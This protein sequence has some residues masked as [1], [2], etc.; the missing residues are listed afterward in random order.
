MTDKPAS[1]AR[2][3]G[4]RWWPAAGWLAAL[5]FLSCVDDPAGPAPP[6]ALPTSVDPD[7]AALVALYESTDGPNWVNSQ[8]WL[9]DAPLGEW[10]GVDTDRNG[11]VRRLDL[12]G[13]GDG[14]GKP[15]VS[16]GLSGPVPSEIGSLT[17]LWY[18]RLYANNLTG[19]IPAELGGLVDL[20][21]L[22][23][24]IN[25]LSGPLPPELGRL[26]NLTYLR[27]S[28]NNLT[29]PIPPELGALVNLRTLALARN[30]LSR[31]IPAE[32][33]G[34]A[35]L[36][37]LGLGRNQLSGPI[38]PALGGLASLT[39]LLLHSNDLTGPI[40][41][42]LGG[43][44]NL[45]SLYL[46]G[47]ELTGPIPRGF[48]QLDHLD[49]LYLGRSRV[50]VP[51]TSAFA[52]WL[53]GIENHDADAAS[54]CN[55]T[56][57]A[58][59]ESLY[60]A[61]GGAGW[62]QS[63]GWT[64]EDAVAS[65]YG[66]TADSLGRVTELDLA[67]NALNGRLPAQLGE[68]S[69]MTIL[70]IGG[71]VLAGRLPRTL[72]RLSLRELDYADTQLCAP[73]EAA[74]QAW[75][76]GIPS[77]EGTGIQCEPLSDRKI[78]EILYEATGGPT[79]G[80]S[81]DWLTNAPLEDWYGVEVD[82]EGRAARLALQSSNLRGPIPPELGGL[83]NLV[84]LDLAENEL[85]GP[86]PPALGELSNLTT[87]DLGRNA[88]TGA[89][90]PALGGL[91]SLELL[92]LGENELEGPIPAALGNISGLKRLELWGNSLTGTIPPALG[93]LS[94]L[95]WL[96]LHGNDLSGPIPPELGN[97]SSL[98]ELLL[99]DNGFTGPIPRELGGLASVER[100]LLWGNA[101]TGT[102]PPGLGYVAT[103]R[104][105]SVRD[106]ALSG[107]IPAELGSLSSLTYLDLRRNELT[108]LLP[109]QLGDLSMLE[110]LVVDDN[111]LMGPVPREFGGMASLQEMSLSNNRS[112]AGPFPIE[113]A[114]LHRL[115]VLLA[116]GTRLCA[117]SDPGFQVWLAGIYK[118]RI[119][120]CVEGDLPAAY[121][122]QA[123][124]SRDFPVPL[125]A[126][127]KALLR[128]FPTASRT[129][130]QGIPA[131]RARFYRDG[132]E[133]H[134][135]DIP[136][137]SEPIP[138]TVDESDLSKSANAGIPGHVVQP[139]LEIVIEVDPDGTLDPSLGVATR[140]PDTGRLPVEVRAV[141]LFDL[142]LIPFIWSETQ[143]SSIVDLVR[144]MTA[145]PENHEM[146]G[147]ARALLPIGDLAVTAHEPVLTSTNSARALLNQTAVIRALEGGT[148]H[149]KGMMVRPLLGPVRGVAKLPGRSTFS[150]PAPDVIA[151]ELGHNL[152]L[153]H[154][155]CGL[156]GGPDPS[157]PYA[158]GSIGAWGYDSR[159]GGRLVQPPTPDLMSY[160]GPPDW[161]SDYHFTNALRFRLSDADSVG[162]P[163]RA[164]R[165][166][167]MLLWGGV[168]ADGVPFLEPAV[169]V[170]APPDLPRSDGA[171]RLSGH[172]AAGDELFS[173]GFDMPEVA[174]GDGSSG[175]AFVLP[176]RPGW[177]RDLASITLSG[178]GGS[179]T[180]DGETDRPAAI[181]RDPRTGT[182]RGILHDLP[183]TTVTR[184]DA[185]AA[186]SPDPGLEVLFSRGIP[187]GEA[188]RR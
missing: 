64:G 82:G 186:A 36:G 116:A 128:V 53:E 24:G 153:R 131:V 73:A 23:L 80:N 47:N 149:Y 1:C 90:P 166:R 109:R 42:E 157:F 140:I 177:G 118:R 135:E 114:A 25:E 89:I 168:D 108:G 93:D 103:L 83:S 63:G 159:D 97:L 66:V 28:D 72:A 160:C 129:T 11:R 71:N 65:W 26:T 70:R 88:L 31:P 167:A 187:D 6:P 96:E 150:L 117:P 170:D 121:L 61:T 17:N 179:V 75:L 164:Q 185:V 87:L 99:Q 134:V 112:M 15:W 10:Y 161:I 154:A 133:T 49:D 178:P 40:P 20:A 57:V 183:T 13:R 77:H 35:Q 41:A 113:M 175:F 7:R 95:T 132:T 14:I 127:R 60:E 48:V 74:F 44:A 148:G 173:F 68:L 172:S 169:L 104:V 111:K 29:G 81:E 147:D 58:A 152:N 143:D 5:G 155:P 86:I 122:T 78:L 2:R 67:R 21:T 85:S 165:T 120:P 19:P 84:E 9:T 123:V 176:V 174:D 16:H 50:C 62:T 34:L 92:A 106:N 52:E 139:G 38:P 144:E 79:W 98:T 107:A 142:T 27:L 33:G 22:D 137:R 162:L 94:N 130:S 105:L 124:Q 136:R 110:H 3:R 145:D 91:S 125:V 55:A 184:A 43:L 180:L 4:G 182:V 69:R 102:I 37:Y 181:L 119:A 51:G 100:I 39:D 45:T 156:A 115:D 138:T 30:E 54:S 76:S 126:G 171:Y 188:W 101:L 46:W 146:F 163:D 8:N 32:L 141:P 12:A 18:L 56:D 151:H 158:N 59:L